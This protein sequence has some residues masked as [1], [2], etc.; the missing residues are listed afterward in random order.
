MKLDMLRPLD[1]KLLRDL[2]HIRG[3]VL[4]IG[5][6]IASGVGLLVMSLTALEALEGTA[7]AYY[8]RHR[9][10]GTAGPPSIRR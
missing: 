5:L 8:E 10:A 9:F 4:A 6:V 7:D 3:Q 1:R 2:W